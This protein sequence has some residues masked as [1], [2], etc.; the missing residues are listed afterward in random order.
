MFRHGRINGGYVGYGKAQQEGRDFEE[1][2][3]YISFRRE[4]Y[5]NRAAKKAFSV[6]FV[7]DHTEAELQQCI[8]E[9]TK[10]KE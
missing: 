7:E 9:D 3:I 1:C 10:D 8:S 4:I 2:R 6:E 5:F